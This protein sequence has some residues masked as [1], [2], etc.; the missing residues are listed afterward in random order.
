MFNLL[1]EFVLSSFRGYEH[2]CKGMAQREEDRIEGWRMVENRRFCNIFCYYS[3]TAS[4]A[5]IECFS[6]L[7]TVWQHK[8]AACGLQNKREC[9]YVYK[10]VDKSTQDFL[11]VLIVAG[12]FLDSFL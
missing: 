7:F 2:S 8:I 6:L 10:I 5:I 1:I 4:S 11:G 12:H 3:C 9:F